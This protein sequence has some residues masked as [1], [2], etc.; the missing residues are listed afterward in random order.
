M[1][2]KIR[3]ILNVH[4]PFIKDK[5]FTVDEVIKMMAFN[6]SALFEQEKQAYAEEMC[7]KAWKESGQVNE[8]TEDINELLFGDFIKE[9]FPNK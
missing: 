8:R 6:L 3:A 1:E 9:N 2:E 5:N 7:W 4:R